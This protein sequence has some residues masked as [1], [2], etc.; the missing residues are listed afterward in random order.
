MV[1]QKE[2]RVDYVGNHF[3]TLF[4]VEK[5]RKK[6]YNRTHNSGKNPAVKKYFN[7]YFDRF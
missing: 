6:R 3:A 5:K 1:I 4:L 2:D 7:A